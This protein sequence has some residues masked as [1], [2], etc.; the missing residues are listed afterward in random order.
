M[1]YDLSKGQKPNQVSLDCDLINY[2]ILIMAAGLGKRMKSTIPKPVIPVCGKPMLLHI[3]D[4][5]ST[6]SS[7]PGHIYVITYYLH[8]QAVVSACLDH[9]PSNISDRIVWLVQTIEPM[10]TG[11]SV[12]EAIKQ[13]PNS[14]IDSLLILSSDVP[15][16]SKNSME[17]MMEE[18]TRQ[19]RALILTDHMDNPYGYGRIIEANGDFFAIAE[20]KDSNAEQKLIKTV[21]TGIYCIPYIYLRKQL[22]TITNNNAAEEYYLTD[23]FGILKQENLSV[24]TTQIQKSCPY[25]LFNINTKDQLNELEELISYQSS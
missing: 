10:G 4:T 11:S 21:N 1:D 2:D 8:S 19:R 12:Q 6:L 20:E 16:I 18:Y 5:I 25:E 22:F 23:L 3:L 15:M 14:S 13:I 24:G 9:L 7:L 17:S